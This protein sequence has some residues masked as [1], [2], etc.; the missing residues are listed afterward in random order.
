MSSP[1]RHRLPGKG[2]IRKVFPAPEG[3][4]CSG[5]PLFTPHPP[6]RSFSYG[7]VGGTAHRRPLDRLH[8][9]AFILSKTVRYARTVRVSRTPGLR[10]LVPIGPACHTA[11]RSDREKGFTTEQVR[12]AWR[13]AFGN[14]GPWIWHVQ[15]RESVPR[16][17]ERSRPR[18]IPGCQSSKYP[19]S[20]VGGPRADGNQLASNI[21]EPLPVVKRDYEEIRDSCPFDVRPPR[22]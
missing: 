21:P 10:P 12:G 20:L 9:R 18:S 15:V 14:L 13:I 4:I 22:Y 2:R 16:R 3:L 6:W 11:S 7:R 17:D 5:G 1:D 19:G 8:S